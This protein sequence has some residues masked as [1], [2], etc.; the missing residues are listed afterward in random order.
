MGISY[1]TYHIQDVNARLPLVNSL[2]YVDSSLIN[3]YKNIGNNGELNSIGIDGAI[4]LHG[5]TIRVPNNTD[6]NDDELKID[7]EE[8]ARRVV[9]SI[10][11][12]INKICAFFASLYQ[13]FQNYHC[14][15]EN[16]CVYCYFVVD[17]SPPVR[18]NRKYKIKNDLYSLMEASEKNLL[19]KTIVNLL[20]CKLL[21]VPFYQF[22]VK[23]NYEIDY[24]KRGEGEIELI[25]FA[26]SFKNYQKANVIISSDSDVTGM[27]ILN[28]LENIVIVTPKIGKKNN[29]EMLSGPFISNLYTL[30]TGLKLDKDQLIYYVILHFLCFGSDY[31]YGLINCPNLKKKKLLHEASLNFSQHLKLNKTTKDDN[32]SWFVSLKNLLII[33]GLCSIMYYA[34]VG[35][36]KEILTKFSPLIYLKNDWNL[37]TLVSSL[38]FN[39]D[40]I[41]SFISNATK[42]PSVV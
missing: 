29:D 7:I 36:L 12:Y 20:Q 14:I 1:L 39:Q 22:K 42:I 6:G 38:N 4:F 8:S 5:H 28:S 13:D 18:K 32:K 33:E 3:L 34:S 16:N 10:M 40:Q 25:R 35:K 30:S 24:V 41:K 17:G 2:A 11:G 9:N 15:N 23:S 21:N 19:H 31:N 37:T 27:I 26:Q